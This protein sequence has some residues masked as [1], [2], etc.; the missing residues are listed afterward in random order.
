MRAFQVLKPGFF[1]TIQDSGRPSFLRY[2]VPVSGAMDTF[3]LAA[4]NLLVGNTANDAGLEITLIGPELQALAN[5]QIA[6]T[7]GAI[8]PR[9]NGQDVA[10]WQTL[11]VQEGDMIS[12]GRMERGCRAYLALKGGINVPWILGSRSTYVRGGFGGIDGRQ[13]RT[14]DVVEGFDTPLLEVS[15]SIPE[16]IV[17]QYTSRLKVHAMLGPQSNMFTK[18]GIDTFF[19]SQYKVTLESDR[20]GYRLEG[21]IIEHKGKADIVSDALLPGAVQVPSNG[22]PIVIMRDAQTTGGYPKIAVVITPDLSM[23]GQV[24]PNDMIEFSKITLREAHERLREYCKL[25]ENLSSTLVR[26]Q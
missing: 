23:L 11:N 18:E 15:W 4:A 12:F 25:L 8:S 5:T 1:T 3:S 17:P 2:G 14:D 10:M 16:E 21:Q 26:N 13:L 6:V 20:M 7:G 19:S 9:M 24:K 22:K